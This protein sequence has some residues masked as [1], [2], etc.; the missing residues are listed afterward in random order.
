MAEPFANPFEG[1]FKSR[2]WD[3]VNEYDWTSSPAGSELRNQAPNAY[4]T[5]YKM[6][7]SQ[8][9]QFIDGYINIAESARVAKQ[10]GTNPG[11]QFYK[12]MYKSG[13]IFADINFPY[14][15]D[16]IRGF[17]SEYANT[18]SPIS[19]RGAKFLFGDSIQGLGGAGE[20]LIGGAVALGR[21]GGNMGGNALSDKVAGAVGGVG[22]RA[23][24]AFEKFTGRKLPGLQTV[25]APGSFIETPQF[26]QYSNTDQNVEIEFVLSNTLHDYRTGPE[27][28][29]QN[30][31]FIKEFTMMNRPYRYGPIEMTFPSDIS[32]RNTRSPLHRMGLFRKFWYRANRY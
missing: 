8:L 16:A 17:S 3:I 13:T 12:D 21:E 5:A 28:F 20:S 7:F 25:G 32:H 4:V 10:K 14:F 11:L 26:Y 19:Q 22:D 23:G 1:D 9:Q 15:G 29:K 24:A 30:K 6:D 18:F 2:T 27:G 31:T